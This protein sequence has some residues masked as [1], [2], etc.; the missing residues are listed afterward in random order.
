M[1][2]GNTHFRHVLTH[3]ATIIV[4]KHMPNST[5]TRAKWNKNRTNGS[6]TRF[7]GFKPSGVPP[8]VAPAPVGGAMEVRA[9]RITIHL[10]LGLPES[11]PTLWWVVLQ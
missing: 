11:Q 6:C 3:E 8:C 10:L 4:E 5:H 7:G 2:D 1:K 9:A